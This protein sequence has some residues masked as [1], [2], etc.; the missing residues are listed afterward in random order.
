MKIERDRLYRT[1]ANLYLVRIIATFIAK[2]DPSA[3]FFI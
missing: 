2:E 3:I 1:F